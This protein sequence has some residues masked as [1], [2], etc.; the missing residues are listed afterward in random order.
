MKI[1]KLRDCV[2]EM[3][4]AGGPSMLILG[5]PGIGKSTAVSEATR[6][7]AQKQGK[8]FI[9]YS[10]S[11]AGLILANPEKYFVFMDFRLTEAEPSDLLGIPKDTDGGVTYKPFLWAQCLSKAAGILFLDEFTNIQRLDVIS[12]TY[13][14]VLEHK[15]GFT[16]FSDKVM[17][18]TAGNLPEESTVANM[19]PLPLADRFIIIEVEMPE[20]KKWAEWMDDNYLS[21]DRKVLAYLWQF[22][23]DFLKLPQ[24]TETLTNFPTPRSWTNLATLLPQISNSYWEE[25][26]IGTVGPEAGEKFLIT[27]KTEVPRAEELISHPERFKSLNT[28]DS[29]YIAST[30]VGNYLSEI[31]EKPEEVEKVIPLLKAMREEAQGEFAVLTLISSGKE[32]IKIKA[33]VI[34]KDKDLEKYLGQIADIRQEMGV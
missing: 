16:K 30:I 23:D 3:H 18:I 12:A 14:I 29:K 32:Q 21:W 24:E 11:E 6:E 31:A 27:L 34:R 8:E 2:V 19:I 33:I 26:V 7:I 9:D 13:K 22:K 10:D 5:P 17:V 4:Q 25:V 1:G 20:I 15:A 28:V